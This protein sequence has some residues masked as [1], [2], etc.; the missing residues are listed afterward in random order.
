VSPPPIDETDED[1]RLAVY[2]SFATTGRSPTP[3][4]IAAELRIADDD[5]RGSLRRLAALRHVVLGDD[6]AVLMAHPFAAVPLGFA[7]MGE[8]TLWWGGCAWDSFALPHL[9][10]DEPQVLVSTRCPGCGTAHAWVVGRDAPPPGEQ[11]AHFLVPVARMWDDVMHTCGNQRLFCGSACVDAW[12]ARTGHE[13]GGVMDVP[14]LWRL[15]QHWYDGRLDR[16]YVRRDP[17][18]A[19]AYFRDIG[20]TGAFWG[21]PARQ[22]RGS[23]DTGRHR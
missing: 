15:A 9:L 8:R 23:P 4:E 3:A 18:S 1:V 16:G 21:S 10:P 11:V 6:D 2:R 12:L 5:V 13:R 20:L 19:A 7:V 14:T 17:S 22:G